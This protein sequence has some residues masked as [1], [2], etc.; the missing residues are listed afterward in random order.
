MW[1]RKFKLFRI[2]LQA[3]FKNIV[4]KFIW[5][6]GP[7]LIIFPWIFIVNTLKLLRVLVVY[8]LHSLSHLITQPIA[9][10]SSSRWLVK[11]GDFACLSMDSGAMGKVSY[12]SLF[13]PSLT[14]SLLPSVLPSIPLFSLPYF[15]RSFLDSFL[16]CF[17]ALP[18]S[19]RPVVSAQL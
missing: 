9:L 4:L 18:F 1:M 13:C 12:L 16:L 11:R 8:H 19:L 3:Y 10:I 6:L 17:T 15:R 14:H 2:K 5:N 7:N